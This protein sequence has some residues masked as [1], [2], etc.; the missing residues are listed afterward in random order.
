MHGIQ[1]TV[2]CNILDPLFTGAKNNWAAN[3]IDEVPPHTLGSWTSEPKHWP[4][5]LSK[6][7]TLKVNVEMTIGNSA[8]L[9]IAIIN[10]F[11][12]NGYG[13]PI[14]DVHDASVFLEMKEKIWLW[15]ISS[16]TWIVRFNTINQMR[17]FRL[18]YSEYL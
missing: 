14:Y 6:H 1:L 12:R 17:M 3:L 16:F 15:P 7:M 5:S 10:G 13:L 8:I 4:T 2:P 18:K 9:A 11:R